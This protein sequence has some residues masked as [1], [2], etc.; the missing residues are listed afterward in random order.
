[1]KKLISSKKVIAILLCFAMLLPLCFIGTTAATDYINLFDTGTAGIYGGNTSNTTYW[2]SELITV[3][4]GDVICFGPILSDQGYHLTSYSDVSGSTKLESQINLTNSNVEIVE[5]FDVGNVV[6][7]KWTVPA[8]TKSF[9]WVA[10]Q[11]FYDVALVTKNQSFGVN[12]YITY[13]EAAGK[14]IDFLKL[15]ES[16]QTLVNKFYDGSTYAGYVTQAG[17]ETKHMSLRTSDKISV[18]RGDTVYFT[19]LVEPITY[20][21][22]ALPTDAYTKII[23]PRTTYYHL[24]LYDASGNFVNNKTAG[25]NATEGI[26]WIDD[27]FLIEYEDLGNGYMTYAYRIG[28]TDVSYV[29][30]IATRGMCDDEIELVTVNQPFSRNQYCEMFSIGTPLD[31]ESS[32]NGKSAL[33]LGDSITEGRND[34]TSYARDTRGWAGRLARNTGM[35]VTNAGISSATISYVA[36]SSTTNENGNWPWIY[37]EFYGNT[38]TSESTDITLPPKGLSKYTIAATNTAHYDLIVMHGGVNDAR[39]ARTVGTVTRTS[40]YN[41]DQFDKSTFAGGLQYLFANVA[42]GYAEADLFYIANFHLDNYAYNSVYIDA[43]DGLMSQYFEVATEICELY[44]VHLID[45][46][47]NAELDA[48][49]QPYNTTILEDKLHPSTEGYDLITPYIQ[50]ELEAVVKKN[51]SIITENPLGSVVPGAGAGASVNT[52]IAAASG[53]SVWDG[54]SYDTSW[55][56]AGD[57]AYYITSAAELAGLKKVVDEAA[58]ENRNNWIAAVDAAGT[59]VGY[60]NYIHEFNGY[61]FYITTNIDLGG[62]DWD[63]I[64]THDQWCVF[65]GSLV[66]ALDRVV[67]EM[68]Y[69]KG[70]NA[71]YDSTDQLGVATGTIDT[72]LTSG[73][74]GASKQGVGLVTIQ[75]NGGM[76]NLTLVE[77]IATLTAGVVSTGFFVG[78]SRTSGMTYTNLHV[79]DGTINGTSAAATQIGGI[80]GTADSSLNINNCTVSATYNLTNGT[81]QQIGG[82]VGTLNTANT[83][84][85]N[86]VTDVTLNFASG[87]AQF[88]GIAGRIYANNVTLTSNT[89]NATVTVTAASE[90][91]GGIVG[92]TQNMGGSADTAGATIDSCLANFNCINPDYAITK[93]AGITPGG[94]PGGNQTS[95]YAQHF[96]KITNCVVNMDCQVLIAGGSQLLGGVASYLNNGGFITIENTLTTGQ[97]KIC[98]S[99]ALHTMSIAGVL[100]R[101]EGYGAKI[102]KCQSNM[103]IDFANVQKSAR[104]NLYRTGGILGNEQASRVNKTGASLTIDGCVFSGNIKASGTGGQL[105][106]I[107][108]IAGLIQYAATIKNC[109]VGKINAD[110][111]VTPIEISCADAYDANNGCKIGGVIGYLMQSDSASIVTDCQAAVNFV[112]SGA[113]TKGICELTGGIIGSNENQLDQAMNNC[114]FIGSVIVKDGVINNTGIAIYRLGGLIGKTSKQITIT[115]AKVDWALRDLTT[116]CTTETYKDKIG[117]LVGH[118]SAAIMISDCYISFDQSSTAPH[119]ESTNYRLRFCSG[120]VGYTTGALNVSRCVVEYN[121]VSQNTLVQYVGGIAGNAEADTTIDQCYVSGYMRNVKYAGGFVGQVKSSCALTIKNSQSDMLISGSGS[122]CGGFIGRINGVTTVENC[123]LTGMASQTYSEIN[124]S[125]G[126]VG[127]VSA[128]IDSVNDLLTVTDCYSNHSVPFFP[129]IDASVGT[130]YDGTLNIN[131]TSIPETAPATIVTSAANQAVTV[132]KASMLTADS[133]WTTYDDGRTP[134][135]TIAADVYR[136]YAKADT[137]WFHPI[138]QISETTFSV[139]KYTLDTEAKVVG[140]AMLSQLN[141]FYED[142]DENVNFV[143]TKDCILSDE[144]AGLMNGALD[145]TVS[146]ICAHH[147]TDPLHPDGCTG[148]VVTYESLNVQKQISASSDGDAN[149]INIRFIAKIEKS[150]TG[151]NTVG[152]VFESADGEVFTY[153]STKVYSGVYTPSGTVTDSNYYFF[154]FDFYNV[155]KDAIFE[156]T[157]FVEYQGHAAYGSGETVNVNQLV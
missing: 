21:N 40:I 121:L 75:S 109:L 116:W 101:C 94:N 30:I 140:L 6:I 63:G 62:Y 13:T 42:T 125:F 115:N 29:R 110:G 46:Y 114:K 86:C 152:F 45:L 144:I 83:T 97:I 15:T 3:S 2:S 28:R 23:D 11:M 34:Q 16:E 84:V 120:T 106:E 133:I 150:L 131:G 60:G 99:L 85:Q 89:A 76:K 81:S 17:V 147:R 79:I 22:D 154:A 26:N 126:W 157:A 39:K 107:G 151:Y 5:E 111:T 74:G 25:N 68:V 95:D 135:L 48:K 78:R 87:Q 117:G 27:R 124:T 103:N 33:F 148:K 47:N 130:D 57:N 132:K 44:G 102:Y 123:L 142:V 58:V 153:S 127:L 128:E 129:R 112:F 49:L 105:Q 36:G 77:P 138:T 8:D 88:G 64:G 61:T 4:E 54:S 43:K 139:T 72:S 56:S 20:G 70:L 7:A 136:P 96:L 19:G 98:G 141:V 113:G 32:L 12:E 82:I 80:V 41:T 73:A 1:M 50:A 134:V 65:A 93:T 69:I 9:V 108:G 155:P 14:N 10:S 18:V 38:F 52:P 67:G 55:E 51:S 119:P 71:V 156:V 137:T 24:A 122:Q 92:I 66:G 91:F 146:G 145:Y 59:S 53:Y 37:H 149:K 35:T 143:I 31:S 104:T 90:F 100:A 118:S